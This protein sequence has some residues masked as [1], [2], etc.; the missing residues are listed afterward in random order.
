MPPDRLASLRRGSAIGSS[1]EGKRQRPTGLSLIEERPAG[2]S[3]IEVLLVVA[4]L[5]ILVGLLLPDAN[6]TL[7][8]RLRA[9]AR[10]LAGDLAY[11]RSLAVAN[12]SRYRIRFEPAENRYV[13]EHSGT[14]AALDRLPL[15]PFRNPGDPA[16][17][18]IVDFDLIP[19]VGTR[20]RLLGAMVE[21]GTIQRVD[22]VEFDAFGQT[23]RSAATIVWLCAGE[24]ADR[25]YITVTVNPATG[26]ATRGE[27]TT[28]GPPTALTP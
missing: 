17:Q 26:L 10:L 7:P 24:G 9:A 25:R 2:L 4:L 12:N 22:E 23:T 1:P 20:V 6:A 15:S 8:D 19:Q 5:G 18:Q 27:Y 14:N 3:L 21:A 11:A 13:L 16:D 28:G